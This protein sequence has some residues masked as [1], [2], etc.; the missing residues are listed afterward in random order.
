[1]SPLGWC[2]SGL[3]LSFFAS[4]RELGDAFPGALSVSATA[5]SSSLVALACPLLSAELII[6]AVAHPESGIPTRSS[7]YI[8]HA[9]YKLRE[10]VRQKA[11][12]ADNLV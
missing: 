12:C 8:R 10:D 6:R 7:P 9:K 1:M 5:A 4:S 3:A 2:A 11:F